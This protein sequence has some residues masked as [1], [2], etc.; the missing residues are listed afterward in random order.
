LRLKQKRQIYGFTLVEV[1]VAAAILTL[2]SVGIYNLFFSGAKTAV[3][4]LWRSKCNQDLR[5]GLRL[6]REDLARATYPSV[7]T[8]TGTEWPDRDSHHCTIIPG[9]TE[10]GSDATLLSFYMCTPDFDIAGETKPGEKT[11][12]QLA[13]EGNQLRYTREGTQAMNKILVHDLEY[14]DLS[15]EVST[16]NVEKNTI[17]IEIGTIHKIYKNTKVIQKLVAKAE[18]EVQ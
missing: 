16:A 6:I 7:V 13:I 9:R 2:A 11:Y 14:V 8:D 15:S 1:L 17:T 3:V 10:V 5:N 4:G 18:V 12:C